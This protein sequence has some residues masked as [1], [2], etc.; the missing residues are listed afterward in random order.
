LNGQISWQFNQQ[1]SVSF[2]ASRLFGRDLN[3]INEHTKGYTL[4]DATANYRVGE[5]GT[6]SLGVENLF[7][8]FY[9]LSSSQIDIYQNYFAGRGR[10]VSLTFSRNF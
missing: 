1:G 2:G 9:F 5:V 7:N 8:K 6:F 4:F 3:T 10:T